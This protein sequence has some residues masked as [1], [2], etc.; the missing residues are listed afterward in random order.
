MSEEEAC[1][2]DHSRRSGLQQFGNLLTFGDT[3]RSDNE[4]AL[5]D[6]LNNRADEFQCRR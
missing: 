6:S 2:Y 3:A 1:A 5:R 4:R